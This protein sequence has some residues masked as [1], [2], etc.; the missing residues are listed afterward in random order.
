MRVHSMKRRELEH[1]LRAL[2]WRLERHEAKHDVWA[3]DDGSFME[4]LP[5]QRE[6]NERLA[7][8]ILRRARERQ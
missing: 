6:I 8:V 3:N 2:G 4:Y 5:R 7:K 1:R